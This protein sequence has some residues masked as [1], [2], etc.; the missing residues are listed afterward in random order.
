MS[1]GYSKF[2]INIISFF[3]V[4]IRFVVLSNSIF[5]GHT[6]FVNSCHPSRRGP[7]LICSASDDCSIRLWDTRKRNAAAV[8]N[9]TYQVTAVSFNDVSDKIISGGIDNEVKVKT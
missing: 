3:V 4:C 9:N 6:T 5:V 8:F 2:E 1:F 7:Q